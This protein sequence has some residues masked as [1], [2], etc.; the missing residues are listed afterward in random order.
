MQGENGG[1][2]DCFDGAF[3]KEENWD[4]HGE[5]VDAARRRGTGSIGPSE[6]TMLDKREEPEREEEVR[7]NTG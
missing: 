1:T 7:A 4:Y 2:T 6:N 5:T 3:E